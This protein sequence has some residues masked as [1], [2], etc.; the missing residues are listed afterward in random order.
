MLIQH[1]VLMKIIHMQNIGII[2]YYLHNRFGTHPSG[3]SKIETKEGTM[4]LSDWLKV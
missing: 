1:L 3:P 4:L 2:W